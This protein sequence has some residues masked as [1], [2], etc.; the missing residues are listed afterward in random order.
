MAESGGHALVLMPDIT[1]YTE[2]LSK[3]E[4]SHGEHIIAELLEVLIANTTVEMEL[5]EIEGDALL[6]YRFGPPPSLELLMAHIAL[7][8][9]NFHTHLMQLQQQIFCDCGSC[10]NLGRLSLKVVGHYGSIV[11]HKVG[12]RLKI[13]GTDVVLSHRM[14]KNGVPLPNYV[15]FSDSLWEAMGE[16]QNRQWKFAPHRETYP[17]FGEVGMMLVDM[18]PFVKALP[19]P[20]PPGSAPPPETHF[21]E[22]VALKAPFATVVEHLA[23]Y[24][25]WPLWS[26]GVEMVDDEIDAIPRKGSVHRCLLDGRLVE[27]SLE[28]LKFGARAFTI[29]NRLTPPHPLVKDVLVD[30][31]AAQEGEEVRVTATV[32][33]R[34]RPLSAWLVERWVMPA[35]R[36]RFGSNLRNLKNLLEGGAVAATDGGLS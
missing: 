20:P 18:G 27:L 5:A 32:C 11:H 1:G 7:G 21:V 19:A 35:L 14:L 30:Y 28:N 26:Q 8:F 4:I 17:V 12:G 33:Y 23:D 36:L 15:L 10:Q 29:S 31:S 3:V 9:K 16:T 22:Q 6:L 34:C 25:K 24:S 13:F 2:F